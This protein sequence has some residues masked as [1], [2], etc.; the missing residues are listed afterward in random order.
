MSQQN[1]VFWSDLLPFGWCTDTHRH[2]QTHADTYRHTDTS[3]YTHRYPIHTH[4][5]EL[6]FIRGLLH[7]ELSL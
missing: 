5:Q 3:T 1:T 2:I 6:S 7:R 4:I